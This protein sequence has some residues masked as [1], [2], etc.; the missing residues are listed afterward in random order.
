[1]KLTKRKALEICRDLWRWLAKTGTVNKSK[2]PGWKEHGI[3]AHNCP[4]C[5]YSMDRGHLT[6]LCIET[7]I[8]KWPGK[9]CRNSESPYLGW[10]NEG[11]IDERKKLAKKIVALANEALEKLPKANKKTHK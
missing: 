10:E 4:C 9:G 8:I 1:M 2:W 5:E 11:R 7:C 6:G 3:M